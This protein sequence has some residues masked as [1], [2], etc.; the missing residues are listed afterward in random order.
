MVGVGTKNQRLDAAARCLAAACLIAVI[1]ATF[2]LFNGADTPFLAFSVIG[3]AVVHFA[4]RPHWIEATITA[5]LASLLGI[6]YV[7]SRGIFGQYPGSGLVGT[8]AF[9]GLASM[10]V[11]GWKACRSTAALRPLLLRC[12]YDR[13]YPVRRCDRRYLSVSGFLCAIP[14][15]RAR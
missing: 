13:G 8:C 3:A 15:V 4:N 2:R 7:G 9:L 12:Q 6:V 1:F 11:L 10:L 14:P 5:V